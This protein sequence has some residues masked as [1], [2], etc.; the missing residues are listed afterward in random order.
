MTGTFYSPNY[1]QHY[2]PNKEC[3]W[4]FSTA[5]GH[6]KKLIFDQF[7][8]ES[9]QQCA[10]DHIALFD[11]QSADD[12]L[13]YRFCGSRRPLTI[14][15]SFNML[16]MLFKSDATNERRGFNGTH[17]TGFLLFQSLSIT[18]HSH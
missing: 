18:S 8:L 13:L 15:S 5:P 16:Y 14:I 4:L 2:Q 3:A 9:H 1:P 11:G 10:Y 7:D 6:R 12:P 17:T